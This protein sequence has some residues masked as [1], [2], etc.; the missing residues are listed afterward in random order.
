MQSRTEIT[1]ITLRISEIQAGGKSRACPTEFGCFIIL[2]CTKD[3]H[4]LSGQNTR[5]SEYYCN[6]WQRQQE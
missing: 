1:V 6:A 3:K 2:K 4:A 5:C